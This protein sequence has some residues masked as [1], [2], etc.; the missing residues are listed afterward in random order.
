[1]LRRFEFRRHLEK[2]PR[3]LKHVGRT[4]EAATKRRELALVVLRRTRQLLRLLGLQRDSSSGSGSGT[5]DHT[6]NIWHSDTFL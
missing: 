3:V 1:M 6:Y 2:N 5:H 4:S